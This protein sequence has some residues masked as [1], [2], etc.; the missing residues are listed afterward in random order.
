[1][2]VTTLFCIP[3]NQITRVMPGTDM[4]QNQNACLNTSFT[5]LLTLESES[6]YLPCGE[7]YDQYYANGV[8]Q[9]QGIHLSHRVQQRR[10]NRR[11]RMRM[12]RLQSQVETL[13]LPT[14][15]ICSHRLIKQKRKSEKLAYYKPNVEFTRHIIPKCE[16][17]EELIMSC[18]RHTEWI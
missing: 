9:D 7:T 8:R 15:L 17:A 3:F 18:D 16:H 13:A 2:M 6:D 14:T 12:R 1:M 4:L 10:K 11:H 5:S